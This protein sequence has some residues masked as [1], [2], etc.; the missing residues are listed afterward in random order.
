LELPSGGTEKGEFGDNDFVVQASA[1]EAKPRLF[2]KGDLQKEGDHGLAADVRN[3]IADKRCRIVGVVVNA[4][5]DHLDSGDQVLFTWAIGRIKPLRELL[6]L[7]TDA[8]RLVVLTSDHGHVLDHGTRQLN[9]QGAESGDRYRISTTSLND[10]EQIFEGPRVEKA[11]GAK[12][13]T[14]A[15]SEKVRYGSK[16]RGYHGGANPQEMVV[17]FA[18]LG[19]PNV[20]IPKGWKEIAPYEPDWWKI[21]PGDVVGISPPDAIATKKEAE[22]VRGLD[23]FERIKSKPTPTA[24]WIEALLGSEVYQ[25]QLNLAVRGA[26]A[27]EMVAKLLK[28]VDARGGTIMKAALAQALEIPLFRVDGLVQNVSRVLNVDGYEVL[29]FER[30]T[31]TISLNISLLKTQFEIK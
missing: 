25:E 12:K 14:L 6:K 15:W 10:G 23:L 19:A 26:P 31:E 2:L 27:A 17:P 20:M 11:I 1:S 18:I 7:A 5:D 13:V 29:S 30:T 16:K 28:V 9:A 21:A 8:G 24:D 22:A 4:I 3:A